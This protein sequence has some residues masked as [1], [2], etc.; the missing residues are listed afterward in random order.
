MKP[1][2]PNLD[3]AHS[4]AVKLRTHAV[5]NRPLDPTPVVDIAEDLGYT[6]FR[7]DPGRN[8]KMILGAFDHDKKLIYVNNSLPPEEQRFTI[9]HE[10]GH[11]V[12]HSDV[13]DSID[14]QGPDGHRYSD[15]QGY[16][17]QEANA[18][19]AEL[20]MPSA[21]FTAFWKAYSG[22]VASVASQ[23]K[24]CTADMLSLARVHLALLIMGKA[25]DKSEGLGK[26]NNDLFQ[27]F[28][29]ALAAGPKTQAKRESAK[30][31]IRNDRHKQDQRFRWIMFSGVMALMLIGAVGMFAIAILQGFAPYGFQLDQWVVGAIEVG[32]LAQTFFLARIITNYLFAPGWESKNR[33]RKKKGEE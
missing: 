21:E 14:F 10:I 22:D 32:L 25:D 2:R 12:L 27:K 15:A 29:G 23:L 20:L 7:F 4:K 9:A 5:G 19:A 8:T 18:F 6:V 31:K 1:P 13:G 33:A 30:K 16:R 3:R 24:V 26:D 11:A 28:F 17:E